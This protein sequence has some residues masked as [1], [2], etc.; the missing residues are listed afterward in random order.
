MHKFNLTDTLRQ[1]RNNEFNRFMAQIPAVLKPVVR[2]YVKRETRNIIVDPAYKHAWDYH[3]DRTREE[4][5]QQE[6]VYK[7]GRNFG[8]LMGILISFI[9]VIFI[10][11]FMV[12]GG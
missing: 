9:V 3:Y 2:R 4:F 6:L 7:D 10:A 8:F 1:I 11:S 5:E 12:I